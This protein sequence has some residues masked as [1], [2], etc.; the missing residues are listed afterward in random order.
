MKVTLKIEKQCLTEEVYYTV[1]C[2][3]WF[4][5]SSSACGDNLEETKKRAIEYFK[6]YNNIHNSEVT[7]EVV[8]I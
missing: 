3:K 7:K 6:S 2:Q 4:R 8:E 1:K 5:I